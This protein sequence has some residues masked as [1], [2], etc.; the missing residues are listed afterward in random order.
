MWLFLSFLALP[1]IEI[2]LFVVLGGVL[3]LWLTL[4]F[5]LGSAML[6]V[7]LIRR[8]GQAMPM[9]GGLSLQQIAGSGFSLMA[10]LLLILPGFLTSAIG[11]LLLIPLVQ[12]LV[13][14]LIGQRLATRGVMFQTRSARADV[15]DGEFEE[16]IP[17]RDERLPPSGW[18]QG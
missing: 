3:G 10:A 14:L 17:P 8:S 2:A 1:L 13:V 6:G 15:I 18:T 16:V 11:L 9:R 5:V 12:R 7:A 4:A